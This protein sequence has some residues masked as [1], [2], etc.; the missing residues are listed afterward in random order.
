MAAVGVDKDG[1]VH[2]LT[3]NRLNSQGD[4]WLYNYACG[5]MNLR[6]GGYIVHEA[7]MVTCVWCSAKVVPP[8]PLDLVDI[9]A[10]DAAKLLAIWMERAQK[11]LRE[12]PEQH[13][14]S[15][16]TALIE[17]Y[18]E[19]QW[20]CRPWE[21]LDRGIVASSW[22]DDH[23]VVHDGRLTHRCTTAQGYVGMPN[24]DEVAKEVTCAEC[25]VL[26]AR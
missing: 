24:R 23:G 13:V 10:W 9:R 3:T 18:C 8:L 20:G 25:V 4:A 15:C 6:P 11:R 2:Q 26:T 1:V 7:L 21:L 12:G 17:H 19:E 22:T 5:P 14:R 16:E